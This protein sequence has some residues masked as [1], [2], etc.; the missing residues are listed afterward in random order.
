MII[1]SKNNPKI[2]FLDKL[3]KRSHRE[4]YQTYLIEGWRELTRAFESGLLAELYF[5]QKLF[6]GDKFHNLLTKLSKKNIPLIELGEQAY[7]KISIGE[8]G[9]GLVGVGKP[10]AKSLDAIQGSSNY[11]IIA[12][13]NLEKPS[14]LGAI[15]RTAESA[16]ANAVVILDSSTDVYN[17]HALRSSQGAIFSV[18]MVLCTSAAFG[19][20]CTANDI[21]IFSTSPKAHRIYWNEN[22]KGNL[23]IIVGN[24]A[25]GLS[26]FWLHQENSTSIKIPQLGISDSLNVSA[27]TAIVIYEA[28]RQRHQNL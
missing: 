13:E 23:A 16:N 28:L 2:K 17:P 24:E 25:N 26:D 9:D 7:Q 6:T 20:F 14:N 4:R 3:K 15:V 27:A 19:K 12:T 21:K 8:N 11:L 22:L 10:F 1:E 18:P 5:C